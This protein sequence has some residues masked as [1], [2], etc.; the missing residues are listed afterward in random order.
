MDIALGKL[1]VT[2]RNA[3]L[4]APRLGYTSTVPD[5]AFPTAL[6]D[7]KRPLETQ[8][9]WSV[10]PKLRGR[11]ELIAP[12]GLVA[13]SAWERRYLQWL[14][15]ELGA[16]LVHPAEVSPPE[17]L[18]AHVAE[19][20]RRVDEARPFDDDEPIPP[21]LTLRRAETGRMEARAAALQIRHWLEEHG[22][23][24]AGRVLVLLP[25]QR[26]LFDTWLS[27]MASCGVPAIGAAVRMVRETGV[28]SWALSVA[29]L[30]GWSDESP[31][32]LGL[33]EEVLTAPYWSQRAA[34]RDE[35][36]LRREEL[37]DLLLGV[38]RD[39]IGPSLWRAHVA[40]AH[41]AAVADEDAQ[42]VQKLDDIAAFSL[43][44]EALLRPGPKQLARLAE[45]VF[46]AGGT[47][48]KQA[49]DARNR[50]RAAGVPEAI[51]AL[52]R[53]HS[54]LTRLVRAES[55]S[56][57]VHPR[58]DG[59]EAI[60]AKAL[61]DGEV[62][63]AALVSRR[64]PS[65]G[66]LLL[67]YDAYDDRET[68]LLVL[69]GLA[70]G[71][72]PRAPR[73]LTR[74][75]D[76]WAVALGLLGDAPPE[77]A[78][79]RGNLWMELE[80]ER[81][82]E[83][84]RHA[85][86]RCRG[87]LVLSFS[88]EGRGQ[89]SVHTGG[90]LS[91]VCGAWT[92][93]IWSARDKADRAAGRSDG[94]S[95]LLWAHEV[96]ETL[97]EARNAAEALQVAAGH[98]SLEERLRGLA[99]DNSCLPLATRVQGL[100]RI[101]RNRLAEAE[102]EPPADGRPRPAGPHTGRLPGCIRTPSGYS[103]T[104]LESYGRCP[105]LYFLAKVLGLEAPSQAA[106]MPD[107]LEVGSIV[108]EA[109]ADA[110]KR[111][112]SAV[113]SAVWDLTWSGD[114][115]QLIRT[116]KA[117][118]D[119]AIAEALDAF[120]AENPT[121]SRALLSALGARWQ[122]AARLWLEEHVRQAAA[123]PGDPT[124]VSARVVAAEHAFGMGERPDP[125]VIEVHGRRIPLRGQID[126]LDWDAKR[127]TIAVR[128]YKTGMSMSSGS[129]AKKVASGEH[130]QL[131]L[132]TLAVEALV[133]S[134]LLPLPKGAQVTRAS[135]EFIAKGSRAELA[136]A[137]DQD[138]GWLLEGAPASWR[139]LA[140]AWVAFY[141]SG[142]E[143]GVF[144]L[145][146]GPQ[147]C[148]R[149]AFAGAFCDFTAYCPYGQGENPL[150]E[151]RE[152]PDVALAETRE[153][154]AAASPLPRAVPLPPERPRFAKPPTAAA[155]RKEHARGEK[156]IQDLRSEVF[157]VA[158]AGTG[159]THNLVLRYLCAL[160]EEDRLPTEILCATFSRKAAAEMRH[161]VRQ[162]LLRPKGDAQRRL[163]DSIRRRPERFRSL[164]LALSGAPI[165][166]IDSLAARVLREAEEI[167]GQAAGAEVEGRPRGAAEGDLSA[168]V[169]RKIAES[170]E[171]RDPDVVALLDL[172]SAAKISQVLA[173]LVGAGVPD[174]SLLGKDLAATEKVI[175]ARW[176][177]P[178]RDLEQK[179]R[180]FL[181]GL[182]LPALE[183]ALAENDAEKRKTYRT[184][185]KQAEN[186]RL[187][188]AA[189]RRIRK[190][191][192]SDPF[193]F[194]AAVP[195]VRRIPWSRGANPAPA[196]VAITRAFGSKSWF[197]D[198]A[199]PNP[200][201]VIEALG[202]PKSFARHV[203][204]TALALR[205]ADAWNGEF[206]EG[207]WESQAPRYEDVTARAIELLAKAEIAEDLRARLP[208]AH[209]LV[210]ESQDT[211]EA[212]VRLVDSLARLTGAKL[213]WVGD[214]KQSIYRFRGA[215]VDVFEDLLGRCDTGEAKQ[216]KLLVNFRSRR[217][218]VEAVNDLFLGLLPAQRDGRSADPGSDVRYELLTWP[219]SGDAEPEEPL[220]DIIATPGRGWP[221][222]ALD[223]ESPSTEEAVV[224][225]I[226]ELLRTGK[227]EEM[228]SRVAVL[229]H[230][231]NR[232]GHYQ[233]LLSAAGLRAVVQGGGGLLSTL[234]VAGLVTWLDAAVKGDDLA[235]AALLKG[236]GIRFSDAG[237][238]CLR[239]GL[240]RSDGEGKHRPIRIAA[241][242]DEFDPALAATAWK[243]IDPAIDQARLLECLRLDE[244]ALGDFRRV[245]EATFG[246]A[247]FR[248]T[249]DI[250][251]DVVRELDLD[252]AWRLRPMGGRQAVA[253][254]SSFIDLVRTLETGGASTPRALQLALADMD[255]NDQPEGSG[256]DAGATAE[257]IVTTFWQAKG[258]EWPVVVL[259]DLQRSKPGGEGGAGLQP[260]RL[261]IPASDEPFAHKERAWHVGSVETREDS[262]LSIDTVKPL[263]A[264][265]DAWGPP[266]ERAEL[267]RLLY[268]AMT[269]AKERLVLSGAF[270]AVKE[271]KAKL[272]L[273]D[274]TPAYG[275][276][277]TDTWADILGLC[278]DLE[279]GA[280]G[281]PGLGPHSLC[282]PE[283]VRL[284]APSEVKGPAV[285]RA[286][287]ALAAEVPGDVVKLWTPVPCSE[288][289]HLRPSEAEW[290]GEAPALLFEPKWPK[291]RTKRK[292]P[293]D[294]LEDEG[295][296]FHAAMEDHGFGGR[297]GAA[298][299]I[300][301]ISDSLARED[302]ADPPGSKA[303]AERVLA[304]YDE[305]RKA[306]PDLVARLERA[307]RNGRLYT[308]LPF[309]HADEQ[310]R[311]VEGVIDL[312]FCDDDGWHVLDYKSGERHPTA[313][314]RTCD[315]VLRKHFAQVRLYARALA[316]LMPGERIADFGVWYV[317]CGLVVQ[318]SGTR[319]DL[320]GR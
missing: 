45:L 216:A 241:L 162:A 89:E 188:I 288:R 67:P 154:A 266:A 318:W 50:V 60:S 88:T 37:R 81:Q 190:Q 78:A 213:F 168:F 101:A 184:T 16:D 6:P 183:R 181:A 40:A 296:A 227:P 271:S 223:P 62:G 120:A 140:R 196:L 15:R 23:D 134:D 264:L 146:P 176:I 75:E 163:V 231:W 209:I 136:V 109:L 85:V 82:I 35:R 39:R 258:R 238:Y 119:A 132:Y 53:V 286:P 124:A 59:D 228:G 253:N 76:L 277:S 1:I 149:D 200:P 106:S 5:M 317:A 172:L 232:A 274:G 97:L 313:A 48:T 93:E 260:E 171:A 229:V 130:L 102:L 284:L 291:E 64:D 3:R 122:A 219:E 218:I 262:P 267:R 127:R 320:G 92:D 237:L 147:K 121:I 261:L 90:L 225:R 151:R 103:P 255:R 305:A 11:V 197:E 61:L 98:P 215:E 52:E 192:R 128:D 252:A 204:T 70:E 104:S 69:A 118:I 268:V 112:C 208:F 80:L 83:L 306:H 27:E 137:D 195:D 107:A 311:I 201:A 175:S 309:R 280:D 42:L 285:A 144:D 46:G 13:P 180:R 36:S 206:V 21:G 248:P 148:P 299:T 31:R 158:G 165:A 177:E 272:T 143:A 233:R 302:L 26:A 142:I 68:D 244:A 310:G 114:P 282:R 247:G 246:Q 236:P 47:E 210:D 307:A 312:A 191:Q 129:L 73:P 126:R 115:A 290:P 110:A 220:I 193:A 166:T 28:G 38:R 10:P 283:H 56:G 32:S 7:E 293:F 153:Q 281:K 108:H 77:D 117:E 173:P 226:A 250:L 74:D 202:D 300:E 207:L 254:L 84:A 96:P 139:D 278:L 186:L 189:L 159:K 44:L 79:R 57:G 194:W 156:V 141:A 91:L 265:R 212:Q 14:C 259:P 224:R 131:L 113:G 205:I 22:T 116:R 263:D 71:G 99:A 230:S 33:L 242:G 245:W 43:R 138:T 18:P 221:V 243:E 199:G 240:G 86:G 287:E 303:R 12:C 25:R 187:G 49:F 276:A 161:R 239:H 17:R 164:V 63:N 87:E 182:D 135:L 34:G 54:A 198:L 279:F 167:L 292:T 249:A 29:A 157:V 234:E 65:P 19:V 214:A 24:Q 94:V 289:E 235:F 301:A 66:V 55:A 125:A 95:L 51:D 298:L 2:R 294:S 256:L 72:F 105:H 295:S 217:P 41:A 222:K 100:G 20:L 275:I 133:D 150:L 179:L 4:E 123:D 257:V 8:L 211:N 297:A 170:L 30:S 145:A 160:A 319:A 185:E 203:R 251:A 273:E 304:L 58:L 270:D 174:R 314:T 315:D 169:D 269:R 308:E 178:T 316:S 155:L 111:A 9:G 152:P